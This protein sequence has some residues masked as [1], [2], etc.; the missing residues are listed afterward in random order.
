MRSYQSDGIFSFSSARRRI[1][2]M[3]QLFRP[4]LS[5]VVNL[6]VSIFPIS[7]LITSLSHSHKEPMR[8]RFLLRAA[9]AA[10]AVAL[11]ALPRNAWTQVACANQPIYVLTVSPPNPA[12]ASTRLSWS[13]APA[14]VQNPAITVSQE[15][16]GSGTV[17]LG[18]MN[19]A[20]ASYDDRANGGPTVR[21]S[22]DP[23]QVP[24]SGVKRALVQWMEGA[25]QKSQCLR[26]SLRAT[27][28][29]DLRHQWIVNAVPTDTL[30]AD[31]RYNGAA[32]TIALR[33]TG[34]GLWRDH[35]L[36]LD[37]RIKD[38]ATVGTPTLTN[39]NA[40]QT[41][42]TYPIQFAPGVIRLESSQYAAHLRS[43][44]WST[45]GAATESVRLPSLVI[46]GPAPTLV[47]ANYE[48]ANSPNA[49]SVTIR[50]DN[51]GRMDD[52]P[53]VLI[54][55][56]PGGAGPA[57]A[58]GQAPE[59]RVVIGPCAIAG[60]GSQ[61]L[62]VAIRRPSP[63][64]R[65]YA[66]T[67]VNGFGQQSNVTTVTTLLS[68]SEL[69]KI[70]TDVAGD[71]PR[72]FAGR[73]AELRIATTG[74]DNQVPTQFD[75]DGV[76]IAPAAPPQAGVGSLRVTLPI[77]PLGTEQDGVQR[78]LRVVYADG[79][80]ATGMLT[81]VRDPVF[82]S[83]AT[84]YGGA[85]P[86]TV[87]LRGRNLSSVTLTP[88][89]SV[90]PTDLSA[91]EDAVKVTL[92]APGQVLAATERLPVRRFGA[93]TEPSLTVNVL[94]RPD[95]AQS[96][97]ISATRA[98]DCGA[99]AWM[100]IKDRVDIPAGGALCIQIP[101]DQ[102]VG[103]EVKDSITVRISYEGTA[104]GTPVNVIYRASVGVPG[105]LIPVTGS[106]EGTTLNLT[107]ERDGGSPVSTVARTQI[108]QRFGLFTSVTA[109]TFRPFLSDAADAAREQPYTVPTDLSGLFGLWVHPSATNRHLQLLGGL[110]TTTR[111]FCDG[112]PR[113][114]SAQEVGA[115]VGVALRWFSA[116]VGHGVRSTRI[117]ASC[118]QTPE[119]ETPTTV[120]DRGGLYLFLGAPALKLTSFGG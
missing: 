21:L 5:G 98:Q 10:I 46:R 59:G 70:Q 92:S 37:D 27:P 29:S 79:S 97:K 38:G 18:G 14:T 66:V 33:V 55:A 84:I 57:L 47:A 114:G 111:R 65:R 115:I 113:A 80:S 105:H 85:R 68:Q 86:Q 25:D 120:R 20:E 45:F 30:E 119:G 109:F 26:F 15:I 69:G 60:V 7:E 77:P 51:L 100:P 95:L 116:G 88:S 28:P 12:R 54:T 4:P 23:T 58:T 6:L 75:L 42:V 102:R 91:A 94:A 108:R 16:A 40:G 34:T 61:C 56:Y 8:V 110:Q 50:G 104:I 63:A 87:T 72:V 39:A 49:A 101:P 36:V 52:E 19:A 73:D 62:S 48:L 22:F 64:A 76:Q 82:D 67:L 53:K 78:R 44:A 11:I 103:S 9:P 2:R 24:L 17:D 74:H 99:T 83:P 90:N 107:V 31:G 32:T 35:A 43:D 71:P 117:P 118:A 81:V 106:A 93:R 1:H 112:E 13:G 89:A 41:S 96:A 3:H